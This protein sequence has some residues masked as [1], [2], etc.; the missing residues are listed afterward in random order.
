MV[1]MEIACFLVIVFMACIYF[2]AKREQT[3]MQKVFSVL[4]IVSM[5]HLFFDGVK[6][7]IVNMLHEIPL[8]VNDFAHRVFIA[9]MLL[10]LFL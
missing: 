2:S 5:I 4:L 3:K 10:G 6:I 8:W 7:C 1:R 9:T